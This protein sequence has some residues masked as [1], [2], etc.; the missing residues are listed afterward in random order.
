M[1]KISLGLLSCLAVLTFGFDANAEPFVHDGFMLHLGVGLGYTSYT[2]RISYS[3]PNVTPLFGT[4]NQAT[5]VTS[6]LDLSLGGTITSG[7]VGGVDIAARSIINPTFTIDGNEY[8]TEDT[9]VGLGVFGVFGQWYPDPSAGFFVHASLGYGEVSVRVENL[10]IET[11][12]D[13]VVLGA[14]AGYEWWI[15]EEWSAG[16]E[17]QLVAGFLSDSSADA[18]LS[19]T[20]ISPTIGAAFSYH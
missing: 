3:D 12:V 17:G 10:E 16:V 7:L 19:A 6:A 13:G 20:W 15:S 18:E 4:H 9:S 1:K 8:E 14:G 2:E 5:G 11:D